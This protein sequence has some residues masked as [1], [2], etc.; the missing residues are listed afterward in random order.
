M[1]A[2]IPAI[3]FSRAPGVNGL[4]IDGENGFLVSDIDEMARKMALLM[5]ADV[6]RERMGEKAA[7][8]MLSYAPEIIWK[9]GIRWL[10]N[11]K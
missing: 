6:L 8:S 3:G 7:K 2:G 10:K 4:I 11:N 1:A 5:H 9:N